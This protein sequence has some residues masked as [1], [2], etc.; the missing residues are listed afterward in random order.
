MQIKFITTIILACVLSACQPQSNS[1]QSKNSA[2]SG[3][4]ANQPAAATNTSDVQKN[5]QASLDKAYPEQK[6]QIK[7]VTQT[8]VAGLYEVV[9]FPNQLVYM[10]GSGEHMILG[11]LL[12]VKTQKNLTEA[13]M[14]ELNS[15]D[16][17]ALPLDSA[18]KEVRG[19][20]QY[21]VAIFSDPDCPFCK[22][23]EH[24]IAQMD[25]VT[26][27]TLL[28]PIESLHPGATAK[29]EQIWCQENRTEAWTQWMRDGVAPKQVA[30][31]DNPVASIVKL[32]EGFGFNG[33]PTIVYPNGKV[34]SGYMPKDAFEAALKENQAS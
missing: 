19:N 21:K 20:G 3:A 15:I 17:K 29:S 6:V 1:V 11:N 27:Y 14:A 31:C 23:M 8:P 34:Q 30:N 7:S 5:I 33:T 22:K 2:A 12:D 13:R 28:M 25:N 24:E 9:V 26:V 16:Y 4:A 10:D 18:I 32:S